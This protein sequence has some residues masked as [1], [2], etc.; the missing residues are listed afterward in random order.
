M[1]LDPTFWVA[2]STVAF[3]AMAF[4]P[5]KG[6]LVSALDSRSVR[7]RKELE[8]AEQLKLE[9]KAILENYQQKYKEAVNES[10]EIIETAR[11]EAALMIENAKRDIDITIKKRMELVLG[12][13]AQ[14]EKA[15][16]NDIQLNA[17]DIAINAT[18]MIVKEKMEQGAAED[19][20]HAAIS[21]L[22]RKLH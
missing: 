5:L 13:I 10:G 15:A 21:E 8:E 1:E 11:K 12:R 14:A 4:K 20:V 9:A 18:R 22:Q 6:A 19:L 16:V 17:I 2:A 3:V 7:I